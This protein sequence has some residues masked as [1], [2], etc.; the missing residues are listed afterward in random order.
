M[1]AFLFLACAHHVVATTNDLSFLMVGN[2]FTN[3]NHLQEMIKDMLEQDLAI[4]RRG[5]PVYAM[6]FR[7]PA[8]RLAEDV[9]DTALQSSIAERAWTWVVLQEQSQIPA[10]FDTRFQ[11]TFDLSVSA[12][13]QINQWIASNN[14]SETVLMMTWGRRTVSIERTIH[15]TKAVLP[16]Q[17]KLVLNSII[18]VD[19]QIGRGIPTC[20]Y[21]PVTLTNNSK[22]SEIIVD[23]FAS[24]CPGSPTL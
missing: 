5:Q 15:E 9:N 3:E 4:N 10:F 18:N 20:K 23:T 1:A 8:S 24:A 12:A 11:A 2:S 22:I 21:T 6:R 17:V 14:S 7:K 16:C 13:Q 19:R